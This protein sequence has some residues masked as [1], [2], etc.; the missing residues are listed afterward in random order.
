MIVI[1]HYITGSMNGLT[2]KLIKVELL[3]KILYQGFYHIIFGCSYLQVSESTLISMLGD[4]FFTNKFQFTNIWLIIY[5]CTL[6]CIEVYV[7][8]S[9]KTLL[10][11]WGG[12]KRGDALFLRV[13]SGLIC[14]TLLTAPG[15][16]P[17]VWISEINGNFKGWNPKSATI[18]K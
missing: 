5:I 7:E 3:N 14:H 1:N 6:S 16:C 11:R 8:L 13:T 10:R 4:L 2:L 17:L 18:D 9:V 12:V 15:T